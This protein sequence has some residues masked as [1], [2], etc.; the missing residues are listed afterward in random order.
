MVHSP[1]QIWFESS[2]IGRLLYWFL[3]VWDQSLVRRSFSA[4]SRFAGRVFA[5]SVLGRLLYTDWPLAG[6]L[7]TGVVG[8][9]VAGIGRWLDRLSHRIG[10]FLRGL[11]ETSWLVRSASW[12]ASRLAPVVET[13]FLAGAFTGFSRDVVLAAEEGDPRPTSP[14]VYLLGAVLGLI[15]LIPADASP[16][17]TVLMVLGIWGTALLWGLR[18]VALESCQWRVSGAALSLLVLLVVAA[19]STVQS[20]DPSTSF[21][22]LVLWLT[23][24][25]V[26]F[27]VTDLVRNSRDAAALLGPIFAGCAVMALWG[28]YQ[29]IHPP[30]V[31][32]T[33]VDPTTSGQMVRI[34]ASMGNPNYL[35]EY[36]ALYLPLGAALWLQHPRRQW[37]TMVPLLLMAAT[38]LLT[39]SRGAWLALLVAGMVFV[40]MR[41]GRWTVFL[42][43]GLLAAPVVLPDWVLQRLAAAFLLADS[44]A[45]YRLNM[46]KG[47]AAML[48][49]YWALGTGIGA[50]VFAK[51]Y[52]EFMLPGARAAHAH[53]LYLQSF[54]EMGILGLVAVLWT[55]AAVIRRPLVAGMRPGSSYL[56]AAV[57]AALLGLLVHGLVEYIWYNPKLL[58]AFW[59]VAGLGAGLA[60]G[61]PETAAVETD[62]RPVT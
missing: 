62:G 8:R 18:K 1:L 60:L 32:E 54:A 58:F 57:P 52:E 45:Q 23:A 42:L 29:V 15:P 26:F 5:G 4:V 39:G 61:N 48:D 25:L 30:H 20:I 16:S 49:K 50:E 7:S 35:G 41:G 27:M 36:M 2:L 6:D 34:F 47:V 28:F 14:L 56:T 51:G 59:A 46:W 44:S 13:S 55:L 43:L 40:L 24:A 31:E 10:P 3:D 37:A 19:A 21:V 11:W 12:L 9:A 33:W 22:Q 17:P 38:L 53:N